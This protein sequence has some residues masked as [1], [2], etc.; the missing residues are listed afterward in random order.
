MEFVKTGG[1]GRKKSMETNVYVLTASNNSRMSCSRM[2]RD[3]I[4]DLKTRTV[5]MT[6]LAQKRRMRATKW[7]QRGAEDVLQLITSSIGTRNCQEEESQE[8]NLD[9]NANSENH[10][11]GEST[12]VMDEPTFQGTH[13][14]SNRRVTNI[15]KKQHQAHHQA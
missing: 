5:T 8:L 10:E 13:N 11:E 6:T 15:T 7:Y 4:G 12:R 9:V 2:R 14:G 1:T 3:R